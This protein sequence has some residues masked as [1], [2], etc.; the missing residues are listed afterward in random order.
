MFHIID[1]TFSENYS[2]Q[3]TVNNCLKLE[4]V[5]QKNKMFKCFCSCEHH[6]SLNTCHIIILKYNTLIQK[7][8]IFIIY[9][10]SVLF[11]ALI[12]MLPA[13][14]CCSL[15]SNCNIFSYLVLAV[16]VTS[17]HSF[18]RRRFLAPLGLPA[19][20]SLSS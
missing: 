12:Y 11:P 18:V 6:T 16:A 7:Y 15:A 2:F 14:T 13:G 8:C 20:S 9:F 19:A 10:L 1:N 5:L 3:L 17:C 4:T